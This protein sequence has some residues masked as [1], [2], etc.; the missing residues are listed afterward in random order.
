MTISRRPIKTL[1]TF[2]TLATQSFNDFLICTLMSL[3][4]Y[5]STVIQRFGMITRMSHRTW[6]SLYQSI[7]WTSLTTGMYSSLQYILVAALTDA[8]STLWISLSVS[9]A[10]GISPLGVYN[11]SKLSNLLVC[12]SC[13]CTARR[14]R[15]SCFHSS[16]PWAAWSKA[17]RRTAAGSWPRACHSSPYRNTSI[18]PRYL[19]SYNY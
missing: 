19:F 18:M 11:R 12:S 9:Y 7:K 4:Q 6:Y 8:Y 17:G 3:L 14:Q 2:L 5:I 16:P 10:Y 1:R 13:P 15:A